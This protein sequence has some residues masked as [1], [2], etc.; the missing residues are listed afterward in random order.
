[1]RLSQH[2]LDPNNLFEA[3]TIFHSLST[4][5]FACVSCRKAPFDSSYCSFTSYFSLQRYQELLGAMP[6][7]WLFHSVDTGKNRSNI[8]RCCKSLA[9]SLS[10]LS[11]WCTLPTCGISP[12]Q[13]WDG[14]DSTLPINLL[15]NRY[16]TEAR[17]QCNALT[18]TAMC[19]TQ[20]FKS[21]NRLL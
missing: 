10:K 6:R 15:P 20:R 12:S 7:T 16:Y 5:T 19:S 21:S 14:L 1:M 3:V 8:H 13:L 17:S 4:S 2:D 9:P 11:S 18:I